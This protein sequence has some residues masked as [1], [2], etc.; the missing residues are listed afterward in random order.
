MTDDLRT[1]IL[2]VL[3]TREECLAA[4]NG[5]DTPCIGCKRQADRILEVFAPEQ[6]RQEY[7]RKRLRNAE[8]SRAEAWELLNRYRLAWLSARRGR[9]NWFHLYLQSLNFPAKIQDT[10]FLRAAWRNAR[11]VQ[12]LADQ[13]RELEQIRTTL[14]DDHVTAWNRVKELEAELADCR[15]AASEAEGAKAREAQEIA[16]WDE[17]ICGANVPEDGV[18][19][20]CWC[21]MPPGHDGDCF[22]G[23]CTERHG[24]PGW[25][26]EEGCCD[27]AGE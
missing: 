23:P 2:A 25:P 8:R 21:T 12:R 9:K 27:G 16:S 1:R 19:G 3:C 15:L 18:W 11:T 13:V 4:R 26:H 5:L 14:Q 7:L 10:K 22:C 17:P 24:A 20:D 6:A